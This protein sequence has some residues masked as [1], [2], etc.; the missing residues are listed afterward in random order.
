[1]SKYTKREKVC[2]RCF[3]C[4]FD[5]KSIEP[6]PC[7]NFSRGYNRFEYKKLL[8]EQNVNIKKLCDKNNLSYN[9]MMDM[10]NGRMIFHYKY[11]YYL[12]TALF[13]KTEYLN[14]IERVEYGE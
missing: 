6:I 8:S 14:Y 12:D 2:T 5:C 11:A 13:E 10:L 4:K 9:R 1:M 3:E 7:D